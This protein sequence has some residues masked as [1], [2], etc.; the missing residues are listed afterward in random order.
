MKYWFETDHLDAERLLTTWR[1]LCR[2]TVV[3]VARNGFGDLFL[4]HSDGQ[5]LM[6]DVGSGELK[7]IASSEAQFRQRAESIEMQDEWFAR[8]VLEGWAARGLEPNDSQCIAFSVPVV[9]AEGGGADTAYVSDI[10]D[11][12][13]MSGDLHRQISELPNGAKVRL[14]VKNAPSDTA[15]SGSPSKPA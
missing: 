12:V 9:F 5:I 11:Y 4:R 8:S 15:D 7:G 1:W 13:G 14:V 3:L 10:Y 2:E 6:L